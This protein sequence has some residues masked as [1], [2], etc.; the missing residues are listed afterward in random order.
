MTELNEEWILDLV[1]NNPDS[2]ISQ[3]YFLGYKNGW[4]E[5][6]AQYEGG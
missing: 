4:E 1:K 2:I 3:A 5:N 6:R